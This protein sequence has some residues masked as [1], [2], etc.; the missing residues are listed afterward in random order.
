MA[1]RRQQCHPGDGV[2][3]RLE[4]DFFVFALMT[5]YMLVILQFRL[6]EICLLVWRGKRSAVQQL[7]AVLSGN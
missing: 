7:R 2:S 5:S 3:Q 4:E 6:F 1:C